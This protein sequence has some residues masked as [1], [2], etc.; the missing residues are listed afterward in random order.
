VEPIT[1]DDGLAIEA[2]IYMINRNFHGKA[3]YR[4]RDLGDG[5][6]RT[7]V[8]DLRA[9]EDQHGPLLLSDLSEPNLSSDHSSPHASASFQNVSGC[10]GCRSYA[11]RSDW[12]NADRTAAATPSRAAAEMLIP[13][14]RACSATDSSSVNVVRVLV[15]SNDAITLR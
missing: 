11:A 1:I 3:S 9:S 12:A 4:R 6:H 14:R 15:T 10:S 5:D 7:N 13:R 8:Q 2:D